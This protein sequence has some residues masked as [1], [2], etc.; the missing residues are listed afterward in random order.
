MLPVSYIAAKCT[1]TI[2][3][4]CST[5]FFSEYNWFLCSVLFD[6]R[7][8]LSIKTENVV[9]NRNYGLLSISCFVNWS[10]SSVA[11]KLKASVSSPMWVCIRR[12]LRLHEN[13]FEL[14]VLFPKKFSFPNSRHNFLVDFQHNAAS[15]CP[16]CIIGRDS[17]PMEGNQTALSPLIYTNIC[18]LHRNLAPHSRTHIIPNM[19]Y[20]RYQLQLQTNKPH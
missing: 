6:F 1:A 2:H 7:L 15:N 8:R 20:H 4:T 14:P 19:Q 16:I 12:W 13:S 10:I 11:T 17:R 3:C 18:K 5:I 9:A